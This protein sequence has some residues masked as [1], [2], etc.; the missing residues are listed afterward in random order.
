MRSQPRGREY[1]SSIIH[2]LS[3]E[4]VPRQLSLLVKTIFFDLQSSSALLDA[5]QGDTGVAGTILKPG[6]QMGADVKVGA[7][8]T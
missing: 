5:N 1:V 6:A 4:M 8:I 7:H 3:F 2:P